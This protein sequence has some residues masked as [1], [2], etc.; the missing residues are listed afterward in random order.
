[1]RMRLL[2]GLLLL[3]IAGCSAPIK[4]FYPDSYFK[5]DGVYQNK[6]LK[7]SLALKGAWNVY[8][9]PNHMMRSLKKLA[10]EHQREGR[11]LLFVGT[12][13]DGRQGIRGVAI[14]LNASIEEYAEMYRN[15]KTVDNNALSADSGMVETVVNSIPMIRWS[16][17]EYGCQFIEFFFAVDTYNIR[18]AFWAQSAVFQRFLPVYF[19]IISSIEIISRY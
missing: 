7:F 5:E 11:E 15:I 13:A 9:D 2:F 3:G 4:Q 16:Y 18:I 12:T 17:T 19:S 8:T 6:P 10:K 1:M 14:N